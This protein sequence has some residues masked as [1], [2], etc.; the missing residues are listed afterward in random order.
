VADKG[1]LSAL[2]GTLDDPDGRAVDQRGASAAAAM[3]ARIDTE[4]RQIAQGGADRAD[5]AR[6]M[7]Q[8][9]ASGV[10]L[11]GLAA[12]LTALALG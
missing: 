4:L 12:S 5:L 9:L 7:G 2:L 10:G 6:R 3:V 11:A 1:M 8:E